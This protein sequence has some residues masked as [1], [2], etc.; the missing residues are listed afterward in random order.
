MLKVIA[1]VLGNYALS[2]R[3]ETFMLK[4]PD[5]IPNDMAQLR[6]ARFVV[7]VEAEQDRRLAE[8]LMKQATGGDTISARFMRA[9]FFQFVPTFKIFIGTNH[10]PVIRGTDY[11]MW[12]R[13]RLIPFTV[14][15]PPEEQDRQ[16]EAKLRE[17]GA[18]ILRWAVEG[19]LA[20]QRHGLGMP[21][22]IRAAT[23]AYRT[24]MDVLGQF[25]AERCVLED[26]ARV[27]SGD[28]YGAYG[29]WCEQ[30]GE[31]PMAQRTFGLRLTERGVE[32]GRTR[33][34]RG[35]L[36]IR[37]RTLTDP[38]LEAEPRDATG[39]VTHGDASFLIASHDARAIG[40]YGKS[41]HMRHQG[42]DASPGREPG[43][44]GEV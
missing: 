36:G 7:A 3:P 30:T 34:A 23:A 38:D 39:P 4:G 13:V 32:P 40:S 1:S 43:D 11:A 10:K 35:W 5:N 37:L 41:R 33:A 15:I 29:A 17:E 18:G 42:G 14:T 27:S 9:E 31:R 2:T 21:D 12:R 44:E 16:L 24:E 26:E 20:W 25:I 6:G 19:C 28:L 22:E 8:A